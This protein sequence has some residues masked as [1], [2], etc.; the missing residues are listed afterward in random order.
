[1]TRSTIATL[2]LVAGTTIAAGAHYMHRS[3]T[4]PALVTEPV[5][6]GSI[7]KIVASTGTLQA[8]TTVEVGSQL[9]GTV[10]TLSADFNSLVHQGQVL[11]KLDQ[12]TYLAALEQAKGDLEGAEADADR[13]R[14]AKSAAD[15]ALTR[16]RELSVAQVETADDLQTADTDDRTAEANVGAADARVAV[17]RAAVS[18]AEI[19]L[20]KTVITAPIDGVVLARN[21]DV[22]QTVSA[23]FSAPTLFILANDLTSLEVVATVDEADAGLVVPGQP[24][25]FPSH[26]L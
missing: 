23:S 15:V 8:T 11:A 22:G 10:E 14:V 1:M 25:A 24:V 3:A 13:V 4:G 7:V 26:P 12:S 20:S 19:N 16:A 21:V 17:A 2:A 9:T 6:R 5:T 18:M